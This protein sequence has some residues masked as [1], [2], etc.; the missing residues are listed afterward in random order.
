MQ[1]SYFFHDNHI[2]TMEKDIHPEDLG[3]SILACI[4]ME[5]YYTR[6]NYPTFEEFAHE[7][8]YDMNDVR[9]KRQYDKSIRLG[10]N[11]Q[12]VVPEDLLDKLPD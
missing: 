5:W 3:E 12:R 6:D 1:H 9:A 8:G 2:N 11:L 4:K 7:F 10:D